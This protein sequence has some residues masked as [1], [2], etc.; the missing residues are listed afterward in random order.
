MVSKC[1]GET[2]KNLANAFGCGDHAGTGSLPD[3]T[4]AAFGKRSEVQD[5]HDRDT[6]DH[7]A[8]VDVSCLRQRFGS[9]AGVAVVAS[10][11]LLVMGEAFTGAQGRRG[12]SAAGAA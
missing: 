10:N 8:N 2:E 6:H 7:Y 11:L 4:G 12:L 5:T 9:H 1:I 3:G